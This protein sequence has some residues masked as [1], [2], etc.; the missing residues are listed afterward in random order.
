MSVLRRTRLCLLLLLLLA[1]LANG[2][3]QT[4]YRWNEGDQ[5]HFS[6]HPPPLGTP[7]EKVVRQT[8]PPQQKPEATAEKPSAEQGEAGKP[9][10]A[11]ASEQK[12]H[13]ENCNNARSELRQLE[14]SARVREVDPQGNS[15]MLNEEE[16]N[17]RIERA[18]QMIRDHC[19]AE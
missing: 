16:K 3:K 13:Q 11:D 4:L 8:A 5:Q 2:E 10:T 9:P 19:V 12:I 14:N 6:D 7:Y 17:A 15:R 1:P 18:R